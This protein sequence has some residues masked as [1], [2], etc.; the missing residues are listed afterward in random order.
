MRRIR[1]GGAGLAAVTLVAALGGCGDDDTG[2]GGSGG[3]QGGGGGSGTLDV[4]AVR[5][6]PEQAADAGTF[7][8]ETT[9]TYLFGPDDSMAFTYR[10]SVDVGAHRAALEADI[11]DFVADFLLPMASIGSESEAGDAPDEVVVP[12]VVD[13]DAAY[14]E[15]GVLNDIVPEDQRRPSMPRW[16][17]YGPSDLESGGSA[18]TGVMRGADPEGLLALLAAADGEVETVGSE[19]VRGEPAT[20]L[21]ASI[22]LTAARERAPEDQRAM[23]DDLAGEGDA[24]VDEVPV[25]VW[26]GEDGLL[27]RFAVEVE[28]DATVTTESPGGP[29]RPPDAA[30][31]ITSLAYEAF[32]YGEPVEVEL[33]ADGDVIDAA[34]LDDAGASVG[35]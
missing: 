14:A 27:R 8:F 12:M 11:T 4:Q 2:D 23:I 24:R 28:R 31:S 15:I 16:V 25:D 22:D 30:G 10:G 3:T 20:H 34:E 13:G 21:R 7:S 35:G 19:D 6:L 17:R 33:P 18:F 5:A 9:T 32:D 26:V 29:P 1:L